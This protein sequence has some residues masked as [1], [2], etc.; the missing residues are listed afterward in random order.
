M[1]RTEEHQVRRKIAQAEAEVGVQAEVLSFLS[2]SWATVQRQLQEASQGGGGQAGGQAAW[3]AVLPHQ[4]LAP[5]PPDFQQDVEGEHL[6]VS[7]QVRILWRGVAVEILLEGGVDPCAYPAAAGE[8]ATAEAALSAVLAGARTDCRWQEARLSVAAAA[9][10]ALG[11]PLEAFLDAMHD[12]WC[13]LSP[14]GEILTPRPGACTVASPS[15]T[16]LSDRRASCRER[17]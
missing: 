14:G 11:R 4:G 12:M 7:W 10:R 3:G 16:L 5:A 9:E 1:R 15:E 17:V 6:A 13:E 8:A 2:S